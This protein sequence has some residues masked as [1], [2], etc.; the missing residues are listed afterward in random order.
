MLVHTG[1]LTRAGHAEEFKVGAA[2]LNLH[3]A[4]GTDQVRLS[5]QDTPLVD[6]PGNHD[7][8][9]TALPGTLGVFLN[10]YGQR[11]PLRH[12]IKSEP[13]PVC[14]YGVNSNSSSLLDHALA[15]GAILDEEFL[16]LLRLIAKDKALEPIQIV[17][18]H[19]PVA[20]E[21]GKGSSW[22][23]TLEDRTRW[24]RDS[25]HRVCTA[26]PSQS[27]ATGSSS[28]LQR[29]H[30]FPDRGFQLLAS[31]LGAAKQ[32]GGFVLSP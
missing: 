22:R 25:P 28:L 31:A 13:K 10:H 30:F 19:H 20:E 23:L 29:L 7:L 6:I 1:D 8:W 12:W 15:N 18:L 5:W 21:P 27:A 26:M 16:E 14:L 3:H 2:F 4:G 32:T 17:C 9:G 11:Y 24:R